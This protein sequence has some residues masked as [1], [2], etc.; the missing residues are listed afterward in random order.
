MGWP[1]EVGEL[2]PRAEE[3]FGIR[4]KLVTYSLAI[5]HHE[6]GPKARGLESILGFSLSSAAQLEAEI[7]QAIRE[8][9]IAAVRENPPYGINCVVDFSLQGIGVR[10]EVVARMRTIWLAKRVAPPRLIS[11]YLKPLH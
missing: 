7:R 2:L 6:G 4:N 10:S 9:P 1:P 8:V 11:A 3:A 5:D